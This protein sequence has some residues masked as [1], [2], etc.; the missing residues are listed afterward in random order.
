[1]AK[2]I[3]KRRSEFMNWS[4]DFIIYINGQKAGTI[5][6]G[7]TEE[8]D[9]P[10]GENILKA[11]IGWYGS[12]D[13]QISVNK[14]ETK[15]VL[16]TGFKHGSIMTIFICIMILLLILFREF[17]RNHFFLKLPVFIFSVIAMFV[18]IYYLT[19]GRNKFLEI[20]ENLERTE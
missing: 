10:D 9:I 1:M 11:K 18:I 14:D 19:I 16:I 20:K 15:N 3:I 12:Q 2:L 6:S 4:R 13:F 8:F 7:E 5:A 17:I